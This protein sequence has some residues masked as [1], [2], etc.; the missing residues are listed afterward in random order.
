MHELAERTIRYREPRADFRVRLAP[1]CLL[2]VRKHLILALR[3]F[4]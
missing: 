2:L 4:A 3:E 1:F